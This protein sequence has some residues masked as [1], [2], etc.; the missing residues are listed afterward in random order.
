M[1]IPKRTKFRKMQRGRLKGRAMSN[2]KLHYGKYGIQALES[3]WLKSNQIEAI[4]R[5]ISRYT[6]KSGKLWIKI[7]PD[8]SVTERAKESRMGSGKGSVSHWVAV[9]KPGTVLFELTNINKEVAQKA[10]KIACYK[11]PIKAKILIKH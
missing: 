8:K 1:L 4:R 3:V 7:F 2:N 11:L 10:L 5:T 9:I 6:K